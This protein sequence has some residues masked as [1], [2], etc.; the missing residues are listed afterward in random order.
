VQIFG[1]RLSVATRFRV[2]FVKLLSPPSPAD[3]AAVGSLSRATSSSPVSTHL[4]ASMLAP[5]PSAATRTCR[6]GRRRGMVCAWTGRALAVVRR[7]G[8]SRACRRR[9]GEGVRALV[10]F[11]PPLLDDEEEAASRPASMVVSTVHLRSS[12]TPMSWVQGWTHE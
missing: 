1:S 3:P 10:T 11:P 4:P 5:G 12:E 2:L 7:G 6:G 9:S 8:R